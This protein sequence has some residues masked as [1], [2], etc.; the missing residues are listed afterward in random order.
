MNPLL[1]VDWRWLVTGPGVLIQENFDLPGFV[2]MKILASLQLSGDCLD[3]GSFG[4]C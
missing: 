3:W 4:A 2:T 1:L